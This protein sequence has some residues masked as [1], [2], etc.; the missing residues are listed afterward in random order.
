ME[1]P[2][3]PTMIPLRI[4]GLI[5]KLPL[6]SDFY[7]PPASGYFWVMLCEGFLEKCT[8]K[9]IIFEGLRIWVILLSIIW[10]FACSFEQR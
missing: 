8:R 3:D 9:G 5:C 1:R 10:N 4:A 7:S 6:R 2:A